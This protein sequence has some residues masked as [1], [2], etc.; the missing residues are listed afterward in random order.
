MDVALRELQTLVRSYADAPSVRY[1]LDSTVIGPSSEPAAI[2]S[3][4]GPL[5]AVLVFAVSLVLL[6]ILIRA[7][8]ILRLHR[9]ARSTVK[10]A[11]TIS[12]PKSSVRAG[13]GVD[14]MRRSGVEPSVD[15]VSDVP[16]SRRLARR[17]R[18]IGDRQPRIRCSRLVGVFA[19]RCTSFR[20]GTPC[21]RWWRGIAA[22]Q[23]VL[24]AEPWSC[25]AVPP[26]HTHEP[27]AG[28]RGSPASS[29]SPR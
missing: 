21:P 2:T 3:I 8:D 16:P 5:T 20:A 4:K 28:Q 1:T 17:G 13:T 9:R 10:R 18:H 7:V 19:G 12:G 25:S 6:W 27:S 22:H 15:A 26:R 29:C 24:V 11:P 23:V 14:P